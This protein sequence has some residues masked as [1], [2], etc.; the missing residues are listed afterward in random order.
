MKSKIVVFLLFFIAYNSYCQTNNENL[1]IGS[2]S[3]Y[4]ETYD[5]DVNSF[6]PNF[7]VITFSK[8]KSFKRYYN[9]LKSEG[10]WMWEVDNNNENIYNKFYIILKNKKHRGLEFYKIIKLDKDSLIISKSLGSKI[11][12]IKYFRN[13]K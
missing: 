11:A 10:R 6:E 8:D 1:L 4:T 5:N 2:W 12:F 3:L 9:D 13:E 7:P